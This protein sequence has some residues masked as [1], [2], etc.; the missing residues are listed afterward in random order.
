M[1]Y[2]TIALLLIAGLILIA[3]E[4]LF[5]P[6]MIVGFIGTLLLIVSVVIAFLKAG[7]VTG[8]LLIL[9]TLILLIILFYL[10]KKY[11]VWN[12][13]I[14]NQ[15]NKIFSENLVNSSQNLIGKIGISITDLKPSGFILIDNKK[16][17]ANSEGEFISKDSKV[18]VISLSGFKL[19]V[20][21]I[22]E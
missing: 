17:D 20:K 19:I 1:E 15:E 22:E 16:F 6:G 4:I 9:V 7:F 8:I 18:K 14:L 3:V 11:K 2:I 10:M 12:R 21:K 5:L 13:F